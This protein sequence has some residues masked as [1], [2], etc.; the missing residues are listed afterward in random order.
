MD[1]VKYRTIVNKYPTF[2][3]VA[4]NNK[5]GWNW[6]QCRIA[7]DGAEGLWRIHDKLYDFSKFV[8]NHPGG[9]EWLT[10]TKVRN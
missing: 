6:L 4:P 2:L 9:K 3:N 10:M 5:T 8:E 7:D 1:R